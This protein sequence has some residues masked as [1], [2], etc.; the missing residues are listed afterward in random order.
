MEKKVKLISV[1]N[2]DGEYIKSFAPNY[3]G[4]TVQELIYKA[5]A[6]AKACNG[7]VRVCYW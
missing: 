2:G 6:I 1:V 5:E 3:I 7:Q 4:S